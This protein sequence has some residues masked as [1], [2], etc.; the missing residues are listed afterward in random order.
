LKDL[1]AFRRQL[2]VVNGRLPAVGV[3]ADFD[4]H[5]AADD[6]VAKADADDADAV[7]GEDLGGVR[8]EGLDPGRV[9][10]GVVALIR[11]W[12]LVSGYL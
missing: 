10:E 9:V 8:D 2:D 7:L 11:Q 6:L 1:L 3:P 4:A 5:S 12:R